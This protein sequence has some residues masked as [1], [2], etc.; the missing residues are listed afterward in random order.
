VRRAT[1]TPQMPPMVQWILY[2]SSPLEGGGLRIWWA[3]AHSA[4]LPETTQQGPLI[5]PTPP[6]SGSA[7]SSADRT[8]ESPL[9]TRV[10]CHQP[11]SVCRTYLVC[12][13]GSPG[14]AWRGRVRC[15]NGTLFAAPVR[16][17]ADAHKLGSI[18]SAVGSSRDCCRLVRLCDCGCC[19]GSKVERR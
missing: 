19:T 3:S 15:R 5:S 2:T 17:T 18:W 8:P 9:D 1:A 11:I 14:W 7:M 13:L 12:R 16:V 6:G 10:K 4:P